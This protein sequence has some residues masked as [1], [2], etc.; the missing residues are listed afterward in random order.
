MAAEAPAHADRRTTGYRDPAI[1]FDTHTRQ[2]RKSG[3]EFAVPFPDC[4]NQLPKAE[5]KAKSA[6]HRRQRVFSS[7]LQPGCAVRRTH[8]L[9]TKAECGVGRV[10]STLQSLRTVIYPTPGSSPANVS[11]VRT[12][13][14]CCHGFFAAR[15]RS[16]CASVHR[17]LTLRAVNDGRR[18]H[19]ITPLFQLVQHGSPDWRVQSPK[20]RRLAHAESAGRYP[21][22]PSWQLV[23]SRMQC[24]ARPD[25]RHSP[26]RENTERKPGVRDASVLRMPRG[27]T[28]RL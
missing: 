24:L 18:F 5:P 21:L 20:K 3:F 7:E 28:W 13:Q 27:R 22:L 11:Y 8:V 2:E 12:P 19:R 25:H 6:R 16:T 10:R 26:K 23:S 15:G 1:R 17:R 4:W 14:C 9:D